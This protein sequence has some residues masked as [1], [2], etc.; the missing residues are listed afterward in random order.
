M[1][2]GSVR[3]ASR[4]TPKLTI[5]LAAAPVQWKLT[6]SN[7]ANTN[8]ILKNDPAEVEDMFLVLGY[9]WE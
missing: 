5:N 1:H 4:P 9:E 6:M 2:C 3:E 8:G 7:A